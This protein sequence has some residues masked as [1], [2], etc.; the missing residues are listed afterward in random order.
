M[1]QV[2]A[3]ARTE[4]ELL[5]VAAETGAIPCVTDVSKSAEVV[6]LLQFTLDK[7]GRVDV[8]INNAG[9]ALLAPIA[10]MTDEQWDEIISSNLS[11]T[12]YCCREGFKCT[13]SSPLLRL[14]RHHVAGMQSSH[15]GGV[16]VNVGSSSTNGGRAEQGAYASS[17]AGIQSLT[18]TLALEGRPFNIYAYCVVP[19]RTN[20]E[21]R[22]RL[23]PSEV[24]NIGMA[25]VHCALMFVSR[26]QVTGWI[27]ATSQTL[28]CPWRSTQVRCCRASRFGPNKMRACFSCY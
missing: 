26:K 12:F 11:S 27:P 18:E 13:L 15:R 19:R 16:L 22:A 9:N 6:R 5:A 10:L 8:I 21:L 14:L 3:A 17:K 23:F 4:A 25:C 2:V 1:V 7:F 28:W 24:C 20:T